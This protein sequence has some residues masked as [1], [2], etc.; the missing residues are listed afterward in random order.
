[1]IGISQV[2]LASVIMPSNRVDQ[3]P[4][5]LK[6]TKETE[7]Y[8]YCKNRLITGVSVVSVIMPGFIG[9]EPSWC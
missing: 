1:M 6:S 2:P 8:A 3:G 9:Y 5:A 7:W 4:K